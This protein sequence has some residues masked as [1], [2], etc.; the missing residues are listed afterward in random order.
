MPIF[1]DTAAVWGDRRQSESAQ[2]NEDCG[3]GHPGV[4]EGHW[5]GG[6]EHGSGVAAVQS[7][8]HVWLSVT[9]WPAAHQASLSFT[10][11]QNVCKLT[12]I[13]SVM[14]SNHLALCCPLLCLQSFP[15]SGF[16]HSCLEVVHPSQQMLIQFLLLARYYRRQDI[17]AIYKESAN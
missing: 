5:R 11:S 4:P 14:P 3:Q 15:A 17:A 8:G 10:V 6:C 9:P 12:S 1:W 7:L 2:R 13:E 16:F